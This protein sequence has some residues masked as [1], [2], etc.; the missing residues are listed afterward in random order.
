MI[1]YRT[2]IDKMLRDALFE[3]WM[4]ENDYQEVKNAVLD[5]AMLNEKALSTQIQIGVDNG[6]SVED[7]TEII[8]SVLNKSKNML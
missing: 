2:E 3:S 1:K 5:Q 8:K 7:Q 6:Y 4:D